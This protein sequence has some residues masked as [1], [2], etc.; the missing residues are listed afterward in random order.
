MPSRRVRGRRDVSVKEL[1]AWSL[2]IVL[3]FRRG[4]TTILNRNSSLF[5]IGNQF[6]KFVDECY[7]REEAESI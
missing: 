4:G 7:G 2:R 1:G 3:A 5:D 6:T